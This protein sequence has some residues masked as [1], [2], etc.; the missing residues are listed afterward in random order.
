MGGRLEKEDRAKEKMANKLE[1]LPN[2]FYAFYNWMD[3]R[4]KSYTTMDNYINHAVE[5]MNFC[6][7]GK[8]NETF[9][10]TITDSDIEKYM[11]CIRRKNVNGEEVEVGDDIRA[12]KWSSLNTFFK[13]LSQKKHIESNPMLLSE[14]PKIRTK[15]EI[16]KRSEIIRYYICRNAK[17]KITR[18]S[19]SL[20]SI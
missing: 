19:R 14:R 12:A 17:Q 5:F 3:A 1:Q 15:H 13:F 8:V 6:T 2:I 4:E 9:Y 10:K 7:K 16:T 11:T 18:I 20:S